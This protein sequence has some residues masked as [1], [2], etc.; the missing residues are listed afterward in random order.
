M[1]KPNK[2]LW[3]RWKRATDYYF[4][5]LGFC[6]IFASSTRE[7]SGVLRR[8]RMFKKQAYVRLYQKS[9]TGVMT[10]SRCALASFHDIS[11][12]EHASSAWK[13]L[14]NFENHHLLRKKAARRV[15][16]DILKR[17]LCKSAETRLTALFRFYAILTNAI[18]SFVLIV[19]SSQSFEK[20][21]LPDHDTHTEV[22]E[23]FKIKLNR[24]S[25]YRKMVCVG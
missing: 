22:D 13:D 18:D 2:V 11:Q 6:T 9:P 4:N 17:G 3:S 5:M 23:Q 7:T 15:F 20:S 14:R 12:K 1:S 24:D 8:A 16:E 21:W 19:Q 25:Q 10:V